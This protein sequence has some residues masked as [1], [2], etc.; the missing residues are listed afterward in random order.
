M[1]LEIF[2]RSRSAWIKMF[3]LIVVLHVLYII[4]LLSLDPVI[5][6]P[7]SGNAPDLR[8]AAFAFLNLCAF[9]V[10][11]MFEWRANFRSTR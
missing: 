1:P 2:S 10:L 4:F 7:V 3:T 9:M 5:F 6:V 8:L 11:A